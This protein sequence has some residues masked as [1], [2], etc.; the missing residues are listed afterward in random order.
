MKETVEEVQKTK[1]EVF[2]DRQYEVR[3]G[4]APEYFSHRPL[5]YILLL[6]CMHMRY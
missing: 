6:S 1:E 5:A 4:P 2:R 3:P